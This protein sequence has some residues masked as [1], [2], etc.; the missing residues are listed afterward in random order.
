[1]KIRYY[2]ILGLFMLGGFS[3]C[4][5]ELNETPVDFFDVY[6]VFQDSIRAEAFVNGLSTELPDAQNASYNR[7]W[8]SAMLASAADEATHVSS[9]GSTSNAAIRISA[10]NFGPTNMRFHRSDDGADNIGSWYRYGGYY[11]IRM[12]N[13]ALEGLELTEAGIPKW[14]TERF[15]KRMQGEAVFFKALSHF[16]LFQKWGGIPIIDRTYT[17]EEDL[18]IPRATV[19]ETIDYIVETARKAYNLLPDE[20]YSGNEGGRAERGAALA[21]ISRVLLYGASPLYNGTGFDGKSNPL[22][23]YGNYSADR[24]RLAAEAAQDLIDLGW[25]ELY[26]GNTQTN[27]TA[28]ERYAKLFTSWTDEF[29]KEYVIAGRL[30][31]SNINTETENFPAGFDNATGGTC[32]SQEMVDAYEMSDGTL[33]DWNN[34]THKASPYENR[35]PRFYASIIYHGAYYAR[36]ANVTTGYTFNMLSRTSTLPL[37]GTNRTGNTATTTGYYLNKFMDYTAANPVGKTGSVQHVWCHF[38]YAEALLNYAEAANEYGGP[39]YTVSGAKNRLTPVD[40]I[41]QVRARAGMPD[42]ATTFANR[43][44]VLNQENLRTLIRNERRVEL[45]FE[46]QRFYDVRRWMIIED[47]IIH[48]VDIALQ[49][50]KP[51]YTVVEVEKKVFDSKKH[52]FF[53]VPYTELVSNRSLE[54]N[55]G[56]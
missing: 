48:G 33:F 28:S 6:Y 53:P 44:W 35:D 45:A 8:G 14:G 23:S 27:Y 9:S 1:M 55:P 49:D 42:V 4:L 37:G 26:Y 30:R 12:A 15:V 20:A 22:V 38:R 21:L 5:N 25:Y 7:L 41:N 51:Q 54:Q 52:Y 2:T 16:W 43:G 50:G 13:V 24:W 29:N 10:G 47:G 32:P 39:T 40:A 17:D 46:E 56:W 19:E 18:N 11:G 3:S 31:A 34:G 36:F